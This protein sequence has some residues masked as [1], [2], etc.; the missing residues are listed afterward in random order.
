[1]K[2]WVHGS[3]NKEMSQVSFDFIHDGYFTMDDIDR[4]TR[5]AFD[6]AGVE[7]VASD[8]YEVDYNMYPDLKDENIS[9]ATADFKWDSDKGYDR[10]IITDVISK[11][12]SAIGYEL[13]GIDYHSLD[14]VTSSIEEEDE[15]EEKLNKA[16]SARCR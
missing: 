6:A 15:L 2:R 9:Q 4:I 13:L 10:K 14:Y 8:Y 16:D 1:M 5:I 7:F 3:D 12:L 11:E